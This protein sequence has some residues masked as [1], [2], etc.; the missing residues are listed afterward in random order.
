MGALKKMEEVLK[1]VYIH[2]SAATDFQR[3]VAAGRLHVEAFGCAVRIA[4]VGVDLIVA[5]FAVVTADD[6]KPATRCR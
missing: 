1:S 2:A 6:L 5:R 3:R 4:G